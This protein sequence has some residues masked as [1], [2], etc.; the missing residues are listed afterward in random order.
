[1]SD[2]PCPCGLKMIDKCDCR[3]PYR[4]HGP[5]VHGSKLADYLVSEIALLEDGLLDEIALAEMVQAGEE[6]G[7]LD[8]K[9]E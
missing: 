8:E 7:L 6:D 2:L 3:Y 9:G 1:M 5:A 4:H